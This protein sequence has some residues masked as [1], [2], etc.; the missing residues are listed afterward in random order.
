MVRAGSEHGPGGASGEHSG[1]AGG[2]FASCPTVVDLAWRT[3]YRIGFPLARAWWQLRRPSHEG[4]L[5]AIHVGAALLLVRSSY[6]RT[7]NLPGGGLRSGESPAA[8]AARELAEELGLPAMP[9]TSAGIF[10]GLADGR[11]DRVHLFEVRLDRLPTLRLDGREIIL[12]ELV[13]LDDVRCLALTEPLAAYVRGELT[14][15]VSSRHHRL[16]EDACM[17]TI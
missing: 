11:R 13:A 1:P 2:R 15:P 16:H 9:L 17:P 5:V 6:R 12:A 10:S 4:A 8:A 7:W 14:A 3:A